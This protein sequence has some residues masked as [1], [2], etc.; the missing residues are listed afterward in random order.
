MAFISYFIRIWTFVATIEHIM[1]NVSNNLLYP[2]T[3]SEKKRKHK[4]KLELVFRD[5][6]V[7]KRNPEFLAL[8]LSIIVSGN[9][10][11]LAKISSDAYH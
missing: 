1:I 10:N 5:S 8:F 6:I 11:L 9:S 3:S 4:S 7:R 2:I